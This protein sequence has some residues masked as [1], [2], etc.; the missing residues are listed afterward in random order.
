MRHTVGS[1]PRASQGEVPNWPLGKEKP[2][3]ESDHP[4]LL[5]GRFSKEEDLHTRPVWG[6]A[7]RA[8]LCS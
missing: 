1:K 6:T 7:N 4:R 2:E 8:D 3:K 5:D